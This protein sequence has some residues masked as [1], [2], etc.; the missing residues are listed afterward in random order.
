MNTVNIL[1]ANILFIQKNRIQKINKKITVK[2]NLFNR[3]KVYLRTI[4]RA[5]QNKV[6]FFAILV[7]RGDIL[8]TKRLFMIVKHK[9]ECSCDDHGIQPVCMIE[10]SRR[11]NT[12]THL[13]QALTMENCNIKRTSDS[14]Y[15]V[16]CSIL[17]SNL[18]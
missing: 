16:W 8:C 2:Q 10:A 7:V 14:A 4:T 6:F 9:C 15:V 1:V 17:F 12:N 13:C 3:A 18:L 11:R 5:M